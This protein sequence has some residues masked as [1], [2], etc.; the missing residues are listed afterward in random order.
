MSPADTATLRLDAEPRCAAEARRFAVGVLGQWDLDRFGQEVALCTTE[1]ATN[2]LLHSRGP[3]TVAVRPAAGGVRIDLQDERPD[4][5]P[6]LF[7][8]DMDPLA[9]GTTGRGL[10][11]V[12]SLANRWGYFNTEMAKT[13]WVE[14]QDDQDTKPVAPL[15]QV[16]NRPPKR[17]GRRLRF[18]GMPVKAA[19]ASGIQVDDLVRELQLQPEL[20]TSDERAAFDELLDRSGPVRLTGRH[21]AFRAAAEGLDRFD[22]E[23]VVTPAEV[24]A[25]AE[26]TR[27]LDQLDSR[28]FLDSGRV[29]PE[30]TAMRAWLMAEAQAQL[31][32]GRDPEPYDPE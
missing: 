13:V 26:L 24:S 30:V 17:D 29:S 18:L 12:A 5:L 2:A 4:L 25:V 32:N 6:Q 10:R 21:G 16:V 7:P 14:L 23:L 8:P 22:L 15:I 19:L 3:F 1:L 31:L 28:A 20:L 27:F 9:S 11:L